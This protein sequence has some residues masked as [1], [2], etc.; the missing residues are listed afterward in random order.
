MPEQPDT[1]QPSTD[2]DID[3]KPA[4]LKETEAET[5]STADDSE[6]END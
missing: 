2:R 3:D 6:E 4:P 1:E 5:T